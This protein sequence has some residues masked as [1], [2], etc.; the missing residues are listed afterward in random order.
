MQND[1][2]EETPVKSFLG[3][4][5]DDQFFLGLLFIA[6]LIL[7]LFHL[8]QLSRWGTEPVEIKR[9]RPLPYEYQIDINQASWVEFAQLNRIGPV[10]GKKIVAH[11]ETHGPF[12]SIDD[13]LE[14]KGIGSKK[15]DENRIHLKLVKPDSE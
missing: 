11:R 9:Q 13:L 1:P 8:I 5:R 12:R 4:Q 10:L 6:I 2:S 7:S 15:L 3:L 14:V